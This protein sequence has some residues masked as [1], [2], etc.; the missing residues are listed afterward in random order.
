MIAVRGLLLCLSTNLVLFAQ[1]VT[2]NHNVICVAT[3]QGTL[4]RVPFSSSNFEAAKSGDYYSSL[5]GNELRVKSMFYCAKE[6]CTSNEI[7]TGSRYVNNICEV[8]ANI[9]L[10]PFEQ[11][12]N[13]T[14]EELRAIRRIE[15][16]EIFEA[17]LNTTALPSQEVF[18]LLY[19]TLD[20]WRFQMSMNFGYGR[21]MCVFWGIVLLVGVGSRLRAMISFLPRDRYT[22]VQG[23]DVLGKM[24]AGRNS[25]SSDLLA[26]YITTS[27][28][29]GQH[30]Q[31]PVGWCTIPPRVQSMTIAAFV[32]LNIVACSTSYRTFAH[33]S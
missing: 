20:T 32:L 7:I 2:L 29:F 12:A 26:K 23:N 27:A 28:A 16:G 6:H 4:S 9:T 24:T 15:Y 5:C 18:K 25:K 21:A 14:D 1:A 13:V 19:E 8:S 17:E 11:F 33:N 22:R 30:C 31:E 10:P 3:C